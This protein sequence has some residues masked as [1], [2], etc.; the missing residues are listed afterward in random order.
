M[1]ALNRTTIDYFSL[2]VE[3]H[4]QEVLATIPWQKIDIKAMTIE[5]PNLREKHDE[6]G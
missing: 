2:D 4:E 3:G 1:L 6:L 5:Y